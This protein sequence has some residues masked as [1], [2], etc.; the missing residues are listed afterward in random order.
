MNGGAFRNIAPIWK[1][2]Q[3]KP[4][5]AKSR[6]INRV[7]IMKTLKLT[8]MKL[9][10]VLTVAAALTGLSL[11]AA[12]QSNASDRSIKLVVGYP[13]G[14]GSDI[15][16]RTVGA[17]LA[18]KLGQPVIVENRP[19]ASG[20]IAADVVARSRADGST[21][22]MMPADSHS[23]APHVYPN[24]KYKALNDFTYLA[25]IGAQPMALIVRNDVPVSNVRE[26]IEYARKQGQDMTF[27]S[28]GIGSSS[29]VAM[30][31]L[32]QYGNF[33]IRHIPYPGSAPALAAVMAGTVDAMMLPTP[34]AIP[35]AQ[36]GKVKMIGVAS[37]KE[38][39]VAVGQPY[40]G[41]QGVPV[42][43][44]A[45]VGIMGPANMPAEIT[46]RLNQA[47]TQI[48]NDEALMKSLEAT[49]TQVIA[50][51]NSLP[52]LK[53]F[54]STEYVR[55]GDAVKAAGIKAGE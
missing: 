26:F 33:K 46:A 43:A 39:S 22:I 38:S 48:L 7:A 10:Q 54:F 17:K 18:Q 25:L 11:P 35:N 49:G 3:T 30:A 24:I 5:V 4:G 19:G 32:E 16:A 13:P 50:N 36:S 27:S 14:G 55:W 20:M 52:Q 6:S 23:I 29:H 41:S 21:L 53:N 51:Q 44:S 31:M 40:F 37:Q 8:S 45:W 9:A 1:W 28:Y 12:A 15:V 47:L 2:G 34:L 42:D